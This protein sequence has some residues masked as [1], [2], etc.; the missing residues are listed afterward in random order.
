MHVYFYLPYLDPKVVT[1]NGFVLLTQ[2]SAIFHHLCSLHFKSHGFKPQFYHG[3]LPDN[4]LLFQK[5][6]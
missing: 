5:P 6:G 2:L 3:Y 4:A 1:P